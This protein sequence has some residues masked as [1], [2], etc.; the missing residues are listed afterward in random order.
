[1]NGQDVPNATNSILN[2]GMY[3]S[4]LGTTQDSS[5]MEFETAPSTPF[6]GTGETPKGIQK[7]GASLTAYALGTNT[8]QMSSS[9]QQQLLNANILKAPN[10][11]SIDQAFNVLCNLDALIA[12]PAPQQQPISNHNNNNNNNISFGN[13]SPLKEDPFAQMR[14]PPKKSINELRGSPPSSTSPAMTTNAISLSTLDELYSSSPT[15]IKTQSISPSFGGGSIF[16]PANAPPIPPR[17]S[18]SNAANGLLPPPPTPTTDGANRP[19]RRPLP[20]PI[21]VGNGGGFFDSHKSHDPFADDP[22]F[23]S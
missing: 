3:A 6:N 2:R 11:T 9:P 4:Q 15:S 5:V 23:A 12:Q 13:G 20:Q 19:N 1:M 8:P 10:A 7:N 14:P 17:S 16:A 22:F 21:G 18:S